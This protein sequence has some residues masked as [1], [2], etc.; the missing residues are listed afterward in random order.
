MRQLFV[1]G[2]DAL[3]AGLVRTWAEAGLLP[4]FRALLGSSAWC[5][6]EIPPQYSSG[7]I[8]P[9]INTGLPPSEHQ[10]GFATRLT[11]DGHSLRPRQ[12]ADIQGKQFWNQ[13]ADRG[14]RIIV[15]D[16]P[17]SRIIPESGGQQFWGWGQHDWTGKPAS[18]PPSLLP[19]CSV[20]SASSRSDLQ[21]TT[22]CDPNPCVRC[23][24]TF[25]PP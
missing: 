25:S 14:H 21:W 5:A 12:I 9:S 11:G 2:F 17:F 1:A 18:H 22:R 7:M 20:S 13:L 4:T 6:F 10:S 19:I 24:I 8:W 23:A 3:D 16:V 15:A